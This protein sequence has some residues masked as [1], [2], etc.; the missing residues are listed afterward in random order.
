MS[1]SDRPKCGAKTR[2]GTP[3]QRQAGANTSHLGIGRCANHGGST[4]NHDRAAALVMAK[5]ELAVMGQPT[6]VHPIDAILQCVMIAK[7]EVDYASER[8]AELTELDAVGPE[9]SSR[10]L[11]LEKGAEDPR[12]RVEEHGPATLHIWIRVRHDAMDRLAHYSKVALAAGVAERQ[13][14]IAENQAQLI[15]TA[16]RGI[17][18]DLGIGNHPQLP[19]IVRKHLQLV[20]STIDGQASPVERKPIAA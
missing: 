2:K 8:I 11:K 3:C 9:V 4:P 15:A 14:R 1:R 20:G 7:G 6:P 10:P 16:I 19:G 5:R 12:T 18:K 17:V 13:I